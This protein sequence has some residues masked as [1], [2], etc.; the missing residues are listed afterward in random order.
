MCKVKKILP[1]LYI[2][3]WMLLLVLLGGYYLFFAPRISAYSEAE[4]RTLAGFPEVTAQ[5]VFSG[6]F[7]QDFETYLLDQFP[8]RNT[9]ISAVNQMKSTLSFA[10]YEEYLLIAEDVTD[11]LNEGDYQEGLDS[12]L[13]DLTQPTDP[14]AEESA[15]TE[16]SDTEAE[17][18]PAE[19]AP[20][21][22]PAIT[23]K[24]EAKPEDYPIDLAVCMNT[25]DGDYAIQNYYRD[26]VVGVTAV[27]NKLARLLPE[28]GK[29]MFTI[30]PASRV[31][32]HFVKSKEQIAFYGT[33]DD[34]VNG[35]GDDNVYAFD[36]YEILG[37][38]IQEGKYVAFR[39]D[40]HWT[41]Y[42][43]YQLYSQM[44]ARAGKEPCSYTDDFTITVEENFRGTYYRNDPAAYG[45]VE[46]DTLELLMP[47]VPVEY[48]KMTGPDSYEVID[49]LDLDAPR[50]D[51]YGVYLGGIGGPWRYVE[52][53]NEET[54]NCLL[55]CDSFGLTVIP[56]LTNN[57]KQVHY[58]DA[59]F[60]E[61]DAVGG[62]VAEMIEKYN[63]QDIYVITGD[64]NTFNSKFL[65]VDVNNQ[66]FME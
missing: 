31:V 34:V 16:F 30:G 52:C 33:W 58:Y 46:P 14:T 21:E 56:F 17:Q 8:G 24:P 54:E 1:K 7:G 10:T 29:L 23:K 26:N 4:N 45:G 18:A 64:L 60:F 5:S 25:G 6:E 51:R 66:L 22:Y 28:N 9:V 40:N 38:A 39:T 3:L 49:F 11:N 65:L 12:L 57:Y 32:N 20:A 62:N 27:L 59:R 55:V 47:K 50:N 35:L 48:R 15:P 2:T 36:S 44:A 53:D 63:I 37:A 61:K 41:A 43:A 42:G 13:A 19:T